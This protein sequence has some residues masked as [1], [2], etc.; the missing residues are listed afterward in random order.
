MA[1]SMG[2]C[3]KTRATKPTNDQIAYFSVV[4]NNQ[5]RSYYFLQSEW[6]RAVM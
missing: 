4:S 5:I 2:N 1:G 6:R 3:G